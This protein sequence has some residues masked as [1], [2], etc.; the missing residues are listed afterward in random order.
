MQRLML[1]TALTLAAVSLPMTGA[2]Q[3]QRAQ[4]APPAWA[5][6]ATALT[7]AGHVA[8]EAY[9]SDTTAMIGR[10]AVYP[11]GADDPRSRL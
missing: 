1:A 10:M 8:G 2:A 3:A 11:A 7:P 5:A 9:H 4:P 6:G